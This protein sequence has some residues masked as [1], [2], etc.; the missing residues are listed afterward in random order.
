MAR[1]FLIT[2]AVF[3]TLAVS[4]GAFG[5]H[6]VREML[7][8]DRFEVYQTAVQY[9]FFHSLGLL[10]LGVAAYQLPESKLLRWSGGLLSAGIVIFSG[11]LYLLTLT[12]TGWFGAIT[13]IGGLA[14]IAGWIF[15]GL[16][17]YRS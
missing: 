14:F 1:T 13:P 10:I 9:H 11:S 7:T 15:F 6:I 5:A 8:P 17:V 12:D 3:M 16:A 4:F 2:G